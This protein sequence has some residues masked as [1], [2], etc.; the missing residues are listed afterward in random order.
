[1]ATVREASSSLAISSDRSSHD[2]AERITS[3]KGTTLCLYSNPCSCA[4]STEADMHIGAVHDA[5][6]RLSH[7]AGVYKR[8]SLSIRRV[9]PKAVLQRGCSSPTLSTRHSTSF[10]SHGVFYL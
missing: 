5:I 10:F 7:A 6:L 2:Q 4:T 1:M 3:G 9:L 8:A